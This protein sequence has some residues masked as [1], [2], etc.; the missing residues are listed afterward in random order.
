MKGDKAKGLGLGQVIGQ[1][2]DSGG[3]GALYKIC[4]D[5]FW[6][7]LPKLDEKSVTFLLV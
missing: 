7:Q 3:Q 4:L 6:L 2:S 1:R 5:L